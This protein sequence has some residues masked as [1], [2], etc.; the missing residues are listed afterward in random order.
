MLR[1][2]S[3][4]FLHQ[5]VSLADIGKH[6]TETDNWSCPQRMQLKQ[7]IGFEESKDLL[8]NSNGSNKAKWIA[9]I[10]CALRAYG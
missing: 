9:D 8:E 1:T 5:E 7:C 6:S 4:V 2:M 3:L 10:V